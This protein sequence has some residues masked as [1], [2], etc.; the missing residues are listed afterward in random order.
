[1]NTLQCVFIF[2]I[3]FELGTTVVR[4]WYEC[5]RE[6]NGGRN[7]NFQIIYERIFIKFA[8]NN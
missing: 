7:Y 8:G 5:D 6:K 1:M 3:V 4:R 2:K